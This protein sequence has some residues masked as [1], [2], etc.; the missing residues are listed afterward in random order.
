MYSHCQ[1]PT[2]YQRR[3][4]E[5]SGKSHPDISLVDW[6]TL[7]VNNTTNAWE[8]S[9]R[10]CSFN[11]VN[12]QT[13]ILAAPNGEYQVRE[14][15]RETLT[16]EPEPAN[17]RIRTQ[18]DFV[19]PQ[20][21]FLVPAHVLHYLHSLIQTA[22]FVGVIEYY[23]DPNPNPKKPYGI[24]L[25]LYP[26]LLTLTTGTTRTAFVSSAGRSPVSCRSQAA[27]RLGA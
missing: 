26:K 16:S 12:F 14:R 27:R 11:P 22:F 25:T 17:P 18:S 4:S 5:R 2:G 7:F 21:R 13:H 24:A 19:F 8:Q 9:A 1:A 20:G 23:P 3:Q 15:E 10:R 6:I